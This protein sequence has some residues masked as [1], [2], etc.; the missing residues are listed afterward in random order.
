MQLKN[1]NFKA[2][3][4]ILPNRITSCHCEHIRKNDGAVI[5]HILSLRGTE[6]SEAN[7]KK[8]KCIWIATVTSFL[9]NDI[10]IPAFSLVEMLMALLVA[11][12]LLAA[13]APVMTKR[14]SGENIMVGA[15]SKN[16][17]NETHGVE[18]IEYDTINDSD[19]NFTKKSFTVPQ[20]VHTISLII[21]A[22]G[23]G[24][25][26]ATS[27]YTKYNQVFDT[28]TKASDSIVIEGDL[29][30]IKNVRVD[31]TGG[32]GGGGGAVATVIDCKE[33]NKHKYINPTQ[34][35]G[36]QQCVNKFNVGDTNGPAIASGARKCT[37]G[38][39]TP[40]CRECGDST[41]AIYGK[42]YFV[43]N[44]TDCSED[45]AGGW[46][47]CNRTGLQKPIGK[48]S[49]AN[50]T[51]AGLA[52]GKW[53]MPKVA[54]VS[55]YKTYIKQLN[56]GQGANGLQVCQFETEAAST[57]KIALCTGNSQKCYGVPQNDCDIHGVHLD[58]ATGGVLYGTGNVNSG[59]SADYLGCI[60]NVQSARCLTTDNGAFTFA[61]KTGGGG[62]AG[63]RVYNYTLPETYNGKKLFEKGNRINIQR[64][65][66]GAGGEA[67]VNGSAGTPSCLQIVD[68]E[69]NGIFFFCAMGGNFGKAATT[70]AYGTAG[71]TN[72]TCAIG[73]NSTDY[74]AVNCS[75]YGTVV[76]KGGSNGVSKTVSYNETVNGGNGAAST[77]N[78]SLAGGSGGSGIA[79][80]T[81]TQNSI[82][83]KSPSVSGTN[84]PYGAGGGGGSAGR[85]A[86]SSAVLTGKGGGGYIG[87]AKLTYDVERTGASGG[88]GGG[89]SMAAIASLEVDAGKSYEVI[90]GK[91][92]KGGNANADGEDG[93]KSSFKYSS[94]KVIE[95]NPGL[96]G[97]TGTHTDVYSI[98]G[99]AGN[100]GNK[101]NPGVGFGITI[102][103]GL[104]GT[105]GYNYDSTKTKK[106]MGGN[107]GKSGIGTD[108]GCGG[109]SSYYETS[110]FVSNTDKN[111]C[112]ITNINA[113]SGLY[114]LNTLYMGTD[115]GRAGSGGGG[116]GFE[117]FSLY[118]V[119]GNGGNGYVFIKW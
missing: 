99:L 7:R 104:K 53:R 56:F 91:G 112:K 30:G 43:G 63:A 77:Y 17:G 108:G 25:A 48:T 6:E 74:T 34:G 54:D 90:A 41:K 32:G 82:N 31:L 93:Y 88:G 92:G 94:S 11:S 39:D 78:T 21:Q 35:N 80:S 76:S 59:C 79:T 117:S 20:G 100:G 101:V 19:K 4:C 64:G 42:C 86:N 69:E 75:N 23:G 60:E 98:G 26:G 55:K 15:V 81:A 5:R 111:E 61:Y 65:E 40:E 47:G 58:E 115:Y 116:G 18:I 62:G 70:S 45:P 67:G 28:S 14:L 22:G 27:G 118:G 52:K 84:Y 114:L 83:G 24:G 102:K 51:G 57:N 36:N 119:G 110:S 44:Y 95:A 105:N 1:Y 97:K 85:G 12:L 8:N 106:S 113:E 33:P 2:A 16:N 50:Y 37:Q 107:G 87:Y 9:R 68:S 73:A 10:H 72:A 66:A 71:G 89:G 103:E 13:L 49:C 29:V 46:T 109:L 38:V 3:A 96:G